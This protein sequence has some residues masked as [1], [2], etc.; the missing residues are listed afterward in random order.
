MIRPRAPSYPI[1]RVRRRSQTPGGRRYPEWFR[2]AVMTHASYTGV[3][4]ETDLE[5]A[6]FACDELCG[7]LTAV[8]LVRPSKKISDVEVKS[9][10]KK[11][12]DKAFAR[13][14]SREEIFKGAEELGVVMDGHIQTVIEALAADAG[15]L[16]L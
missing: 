9:V 8:A 16:G 1:R 12:K 13:A 6:L 10:V 14:V 2:R 11:L 15:R 3:A 4:R 5:K 7:F